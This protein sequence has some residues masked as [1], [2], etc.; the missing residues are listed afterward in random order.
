MQTSVVIH[1]KAVAVELS[2]AAAEALALRSMPLL[3]EM[4]LYFSCLI[5]KRVR[6]REG[7]A[8]P[9]YVGVADGLAVRFHPVMTKSC[10]IGSLGDDAPPVSDFP[11]ANPAAFVPHWLRIDFAAGEWRGEF[12][13]D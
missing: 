6:F 7:P 10:R 11:V 3:A 8:E 5:R 1:G 12:G 13:Y 9:D 4:E 2:R